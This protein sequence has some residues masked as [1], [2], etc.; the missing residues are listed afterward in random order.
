MKLFHGVLQLRK[1]PKVERL[2]IDNLILAGSKIV[3]TPNITV[4]VVYSGSNTK[5][6]LNADYMH[7]KPLAMQ[8]Y[9]NLIHDL[10][11][12]I[13]ICLSIISYFVVIARAKTSSALERYDPEANSALRSIGFQL[14]YLVFMPMALQ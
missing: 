7:K 3:N 13:I 4:I 8:S 6:Q 5:I 9:I 10:T 2:N 11:I 1:D 12:I 14:L